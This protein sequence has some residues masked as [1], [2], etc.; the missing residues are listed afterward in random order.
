MRLRLLLG[1]L[2]VLAS[3]LPFLLAMMALCGCGSVLDRLS[4]RLWLR[5]RGLGCG[6]G[7]LSFGLHFFIGALGRL[8]RLGFAW[9]A[10]FGLFSG[11]SFFGRCF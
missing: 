8:L 9:A 4:L 7:F 1:L 3:V 5:L 10:A 2:G 11:H 6:S